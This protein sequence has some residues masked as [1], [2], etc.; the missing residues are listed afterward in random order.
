MAIFSWWRRRQ[1]RLTA[2]LQAIVEQLDT[3]IQVSG[4]QSAESEQM[5]L[6]F[7]KLTAALNRATTSM[8][9]LTA[10]VKAQSETIEGLTAELAGKPEEQQAVDDAT[11]ALT[12]AADKADAVKPRA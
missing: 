11:A 3:M 4:R 9:K 1:H 5:A 7:S 10:T 8:E 6:D 2:V 12:A